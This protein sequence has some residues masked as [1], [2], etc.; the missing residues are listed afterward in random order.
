MARRRRSRRGSGPRWCSR[1][2]QAI[3][4]SIQRDLAAAGEQSTIR[5]REPAIAS[6]ISSPRSC[7]AASSCRS[8]KIGASRLGTGPWSVSLPTSRGGTWNSSKLFVQP[9]GDRRILMAVA[10]ERHVTLWGAGRRARERSAANGSRQLGK[11]GHRPPRSIPVNLAINM[12][13]VNHGESGVRLGRIGAAATICAR[14]VLNPSLAHDRA[15]PVAPDHGRQRRRRRRRAGHRADDDQHA[16]LR[17]QGDDR[18]DPPLRGGRRRHHPRLLP[19]RRIDRGAEAR[20][21]ARRACRSSPTSIS[22]TSAR[23]KRPTPARPA[24]ASTP[25]TS[26]RPSGSREVVNAAK[27]NGCA[28][29][30]GVNAGS[31]EKD[32]LEKYGEPCPEALVESA[33]DHIRLLEDHDFREYKVAVKASATCS[34]RSPPI[35]SSPTRSI[36]RSTSASPRPAGSIGGTVKSRDRHRL[37][38]VGRDR[39]HDPRLAV[40]RARGGSPRR[41]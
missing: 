26:A 11:L 13:A 23:S 28:I 17:R 5:K 4:S 20:S 34:S 1:L 33:L 40:G 15:P 22:T 31:L 16:D 8:R 41:L 7:A 18:P 24:C 3:S 38:A 27:A 14:H 32:L 10:Q 25:A 21:S 19:R 6:S 2:K 35:S 36:A 39:R 9:I 29:R 37:A 30:I 12:T